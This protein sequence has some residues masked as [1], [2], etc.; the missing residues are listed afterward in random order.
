[1]TE[2]ELLDTWRAAL[3]QGLEPDD[4]RSFMSVP[5]LCDKLGLSETA[6][7]RW[8]RVNKDRLETRRVIRKSNHVNLYRLKS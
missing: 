8:V 6:V 4:D 3:T 5:E 1:M 7:R 2:Q